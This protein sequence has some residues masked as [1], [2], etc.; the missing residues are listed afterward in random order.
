M[1]GWSTVR[2]MMLFT[3]QFHAVSDTFSFCHAEVLN[4]ELYV[5]GR[6]L[7]CCQLNVRSDS[8][9]FICDRDTCVLF[10]RMELAHSLL[11]NEEAL[12]HIT[13]AKRAVFIFEWLRFLDKVLIAA[14]KVKHHQNPVCMWGNHCH[15]SLCLILL[16]VKSNIA[17]WIG[18]QCCFYFSNLFS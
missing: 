14:N 10:V 12:A 6:T 11:L 2:L 15:K 5:T 1:R 8:I 4:T 16:L 13:E 18:F 7:S 17:S 9:L 3:E